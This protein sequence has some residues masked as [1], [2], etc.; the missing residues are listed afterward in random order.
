MIDKALAK[1][2]IEILQCSRAE[3]DRAELISRRI[4]DPDARNSLKLALGRASL[5][6][7][8]KAMGQIILAHPELDPYQKPK[9][10]E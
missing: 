4:E 8:S 6:L 3:I 1:E 9:E 5:D 2:I 10:R 7:Y